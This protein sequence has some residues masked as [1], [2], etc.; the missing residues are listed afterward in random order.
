MYIDTLARAVELVAEMTWDTWWALVLGLTI[1][2]AVEVFVGEEQLT[3]LLGGDGWR[4]ASLGAAFGVASSSCSYSAVGTTKTLFKKGASGAASLGAFMFAST[5]L[6]V[7][8]GLVLWVLL[9]WQFVVGEYLG[10]VVAVAVMVLLFRHVIPESWVEA[11]REHVRTHDESVC[12]TCDMTVEPGAD[13][14]EIVVEDVDGRTEYFCCSGCL[15]V[16]RSTGDGGALFSRAGWTSAAS[17]TMKDWEMIGRDLVLGFVIAGVV[18]AAVP[19]TWWTA[20]F[21]TQGTFEGVVINATIAVLIGVLTFMCSVGNVPFALV[22]WRNGL[23]FGGVL[24]FIY[25]DLIIPPLVNLYRRYYGTRM[26]ATLFVSLF[27]AAVVAGVVVHYLVT[28]AGIVPSQGVVGGTIS[29]EY[30]TVLNLVFTPVFAG[31]VLATYGLDAVEEKLRDWAGEVYYA[32][33]LAWVGLSM[34]FLAVAGAL[35]WLRDR[36]SSL[37]ASLT[38]ADA[39]DDDL[40]RDAEQSTP[41]RRAEYYAWLVVLGFSQVVRTAWRAAVGLGDAVQRLGAGAWS[42]GRTVATAIRRTWIHVRSW[43]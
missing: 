23:P 6:V 2:G 43:R 14:D 26:A 25:A 16:Y 34:G 36:L 40:D 22:L 11:A 13:P 33:L 28:W 4:E 27:F 42:L 35:Y 10:G 41:R 7:E 18:G 31:Q 21:G 32:L 12:A 3:G 30:T 39:G 8:L 24:A 19:E 17:A 29:N 1:S 37:H 15:Q 5:D 9:G 20:L 38:T